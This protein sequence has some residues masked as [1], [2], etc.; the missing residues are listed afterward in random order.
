MAL[1]GVIRPHSSPLALSRPT[2]PPTVASKKASKRKS[3]GTPAA[4]KPSSKRGRTGAVS[5]A[6]MTQETLLPVSN[7]EDSDSSDENEFV[8]APP[9]RQQTAGKKKAVRKYK[10]ASDDDDDDNND[11]DDDDDDDEHVEATP[12]KAQIKQRKA[13]TVA[14]DEAESED[15]ASEPLVAMLDDAETQA[16]PGDV[17]V[18]DTQDPM[19]PFD[20]D[21]ETQAMMPS[22]V[23]E[24]MP[25]MLDTSRANE[26][27]DTETFETSQEPVARSGALDTY[28]DTEAF[29]MSGDHGEKAKV[30]PSK[31]KLTKHKS[32]KVKTAKSPEAKAKVMSP[33]AN[34]P[35]SAA[36]PA[37][38]PESAS[39]T[40]SVA[41]TTPPPVATP[42][43]AARTNTVDS[44]V[45]AMSP[46]DD[47]KSDDVSTPVSA[48]VV[49]HPE[50][51]ARTTRAPAKTPK[52]KT[53]KRNAKPRR[54]STGSKRAAPMKK[55]ATPSKR[56]T[57]RGKVPQKAT[58]PQRVTPMKQKK[59]AAKKPPPQPTALKD[60]S[61]TQNAATSKR[62]TLRKQK[63]TPQKKAAAKKPAP[64]LKALKDSSSTSSGAGTAAPKPGALV[65]R[66][67]LSGL[68]SADK[69]CVLAAIQSFDCE[70]DE[71]VTDATTHVISGT[72]RTIK[73]MMGIACGCWIVDPAFAL[74][75]LER[76][77][78]QNETKY[79]R[80]KVFPGA[81]ITRALRE[82]AGAASGPYKHKVFAAASVGT[83]FISDK[84]MASAISKLVKL[85]GLSTVRTTR[86]ADVILGKELFSTRTDQQTVKPEW[87]FD[88]ISQG[89]LQPVAG[90]VI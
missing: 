18:D 52:A 87:M 7:D 40:A 81:K 42:N 41:F 58:A 30:S 56:T 39:G 55:G 69:D 8:P 82:K 13:W 53:P 80:H 72:G 90:Y 31:P 86:E 68:A 75:S 29:V 28:D 63:G 74:V 3:I 9:R 21:D 36:T 20:A 77:K 12:R 22:V 19:V 10:F 34:S 5:S 84:G 4:A 62:A 2:S 27:D 44:G 32:H 24:T 88:S 14:M 61:N 73:V 11:D 33:V 15:G 70:V 71:V 78:W 17:L 43:A 46:L 64:Q 89:A 79:E 6:Q 83:V 25:M 1:S 23:E 60:S 59:A 66:F 57:P 49:L 37:V 26:D 85:T 76:G 45:H 38:S 50:H 65:H 67:V 47:T 35:K 51:T 48:I 16:V 54:S